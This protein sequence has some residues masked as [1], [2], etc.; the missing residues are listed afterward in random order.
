MT[1]TDRDWYCTRCGGANRAGRSFCS[2]CGIK[3]KEGPSP[4]G[5]EAAG[6][7]S[8]GADTPMLYASIAGG[9]LHDPR[10]RRFLALAAAAGALVAVAIGA[11][12]LLLGGEDGTPSAQET[13]VSQAPSDSSTATPPT[14]G[15]TPTSTNS[16]PADSAPVSATVRRTRGV[17]GTDDGFVSV[18]R[19]PAPDSP[20]VKK[21][22]E[23]SAIRL[24]CQLRGP[25]VK[26][27][28]VGRSTT[29]WARTADG[30]YV[31]NA[32]L[33]APRLRYGQ[34]T[35]PRCR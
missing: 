22:Y 2:Q 6:S 23:G 25:P 29:V 21:V 17:E 34:I 12:L 16:K 27:S 26:A 4:T 33:K 31:T 19:R 1:A 5:G 18:R 32:Y 10:R 9:R 8:D 13:A 15:D 11:S 35:L 30:D 20:E 28:T 14:P 7:A 24:E 3:R